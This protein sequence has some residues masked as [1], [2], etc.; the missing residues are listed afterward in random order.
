MLNR[1][2]MNLRAAQPF[3]EL[4]LQRLRLLPNGDFTTDNTDHLGSFF[5]NYQ[6]HGIR[7]L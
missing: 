2:H 4:F 3:I 7:Q 5:G 6:T 1:R